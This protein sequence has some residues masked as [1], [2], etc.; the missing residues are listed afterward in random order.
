MMFNWFI[1][2]AF[3]DSSDNILNLPVTYRQF[4][5][6]REIWPCSVMAL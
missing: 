1:L 6:Y 5:T 3:S 4:S 2:Q